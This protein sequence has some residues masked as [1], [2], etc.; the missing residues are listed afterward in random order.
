MIVLK[1]TLKLAYIIKKKTLKLAYIKNP[2]SKSDL[3][4]H[5]AALPR[6]PSGELKET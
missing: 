1:K 4:S 3:A 5:Q 6:P 2:I